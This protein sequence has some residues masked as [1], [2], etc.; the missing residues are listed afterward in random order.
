VGN[1]SAEH[2]GNLPA[3]Q[4][5]GRYREYTM[6]TIKVPEA[7]QAERLRFLDFLEANCPE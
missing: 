7:L 5:F 6:N 4:V 3:L 1:W 2:R